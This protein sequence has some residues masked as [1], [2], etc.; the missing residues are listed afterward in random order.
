MKKLSIKLF[1]ITS[2]IFYSCEKENIE[3]QTVQ[4]IKEDT[5]INAA[6]WFG[7][8]NSFKGKVF[9]NQGLFIGD[10]PQYTGS[11][12]GTLIV[13]S[14]PNG[15]NSCYQIMQ[16]EVEN[17]KDFTFYV[18]GSEFKGSDRFRVKI[19]PNEDGP[20]PTVST[21]LYLGPAY[22]E[23]KHLGLSNITFFA[24]IYNNISIDFPD[25]CQ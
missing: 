23:V 15:N 7:Y 18:L 1:V 2:I 20:Y 5:G 22:G 13:E 12:T 17:G 6:K 11:R 14:C 16:R 8:C 21:R 10:L 24:S 19:I 25:V 3:D 4:Q 9:F